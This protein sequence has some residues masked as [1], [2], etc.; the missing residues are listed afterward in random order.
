MEACAKAYSLFDI[1][2]ELSVSQTSFQQRLKARGSW[3]I[4]FDADGH[5]I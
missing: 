1:W 5:T 2:I 3:Y 4:D